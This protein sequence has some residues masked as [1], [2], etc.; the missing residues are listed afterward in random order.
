MNNLFI[1][2]SYTFFDYNE[3]LFHIFYFSTENKFLLLK[4]NAST[5]QDYG[6]SKNNWKFYK[7]ENPITLS[8]KAYNEG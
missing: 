7:L 4:C 8:G 1:T 3:K 6:F 5:T 2:Y